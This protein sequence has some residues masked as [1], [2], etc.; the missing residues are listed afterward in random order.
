MTTCGPKCPLLGNDDQNI[1][2]AKKGEPVGEIPHIDF[3]FGESTM[4]TWS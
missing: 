4:E 2:V 1:Q 3:I